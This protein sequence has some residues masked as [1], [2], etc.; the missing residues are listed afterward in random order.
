MPVGADCAHGGD[1][2]ALES[3]DTPSLVNSR[4]GRIPTF[5]LTIDPCQE[6]DGGFSF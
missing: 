4:M 1:H 6:T 5:K 3:Y 2:V